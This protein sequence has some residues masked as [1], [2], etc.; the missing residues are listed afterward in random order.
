MWIRVNGVDRK[1]IGVWIG[2][3]GVARKVT[4]GYIG[5]DGVARKFYP[6]LP[7]GI[8]S[9]DYRIDLNSAVGVVNDYFCGI[10]DDTLR[11]MI[12]TTF[13]SGTDTDRLSSC[14]FIYIDESLIGSTVE[15]T[16]KCS[17]T[18]TPST[19]KNDMGI[20]FRM[21]DNTAE[22]PNLYSNTSYLTRTYTIPD[23]TTRIEIG[24][25]QGTNNS[26]TSN[27]YIS[28]LIVGENELIGVI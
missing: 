18:I 17:S 9:Y 13:T 4:N 12:N 21:D 22:I 5:I 25:W 1:V 27:F 3:N 11:F 20:R 2:V 10:E 15:I 8:L 26:C 6:G 28:S 14:L 19:N 23:S 16:S 24:I 7:S